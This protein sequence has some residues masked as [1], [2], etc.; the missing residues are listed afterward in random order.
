MEEPMTYQ[1][2]K[3]ALETFGIT[4]RATI[5]QIKQRHRELVKMH[6]PD[7]SDAAEPAMIRKINVAYEILTTYCAD[8]RY[9][10]TE[11][12]FLE[13]NPA[14]RLR[15]QFRSDPLWGGRQEEE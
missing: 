10:F 5:E 8:Y 13:Q 2:L 6:H 4:G 3:A 9:C 12:E 14:E 7:K 11:E 15:R 1:K